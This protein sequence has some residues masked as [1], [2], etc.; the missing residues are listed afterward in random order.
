M[1]E[2]YY[3]MSI[4]VLLNVM[5][6]LKCSELKGFIMGGG[7]VLNTIVLLIL[8]VVISS[9]LPYSMIQICTNYEDFDNKNVRDKLHN[10][11]EGSNLKSLMSCLIQVSF[12]TR[13]VASAFVL[14]CFD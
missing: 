4:S 10:L 2:G 1:I 12:M 7:N 5:V 14:V 9:L 3:E 6:L 11:I 13:K 8:I